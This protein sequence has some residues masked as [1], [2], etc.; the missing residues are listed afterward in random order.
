MTDAPT[1]KPRRAPRPRPR[2]R[3]ELLAREQADW[4]EL[5]ATW[6]GLP[7]AALL[8]PGACGPEWSVKDTLNHL[9][10]WLEATLRIV[11]ELAAGRR[12][13]LGHGV[14]RFNVL[15]FAADRDR[16]L[17]ATRRRLSRARREVLALFDRVPDEALL[18]PNRRIGWW[19]KY[20]TYAHYSMHVWELSQFRQRWLGGADRPARRRK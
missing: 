18:D 8:L 14:E 12:A 20:N 2:T 9:A 4:D 10:A 11:P 19:I 7:E 16:S 17:A 13:T 1:P 5:R 3:A 15:Q 6:Q